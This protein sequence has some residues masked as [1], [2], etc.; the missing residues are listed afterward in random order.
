MLLKGRPEPFPEF[1][2][3]IRAAFRPAESFAPGF[4]SQVDRLQ[5]AQLDSF[6]RP[7]SADYESRQMHGPLA[8][9]A[10]LPEW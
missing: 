7:A 4:D 9:C 10:V 5:G 2:A 3:R 1:G 6:D 8:Q